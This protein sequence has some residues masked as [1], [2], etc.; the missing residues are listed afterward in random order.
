MT[1]SLPPVPGLPP[2]P[3]QSA[4]AAAAGKPAK[5]QPSQQ[6]IEAILARTAQEHR[7]S[8][9]G[10]QQ[11]PFEIVSSWL[12]RGMIARLL[13]VMSGLIL[14]NNGFDGLK[15]RAVS[16]DSLIAVS[17][18]NQGGQSVGLGFA[19]L[20]FAVIPFSSRKRD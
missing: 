11:S 8:F 17:I 10:Q 15:T 1:D 6:E 18:N 4:S 12:A 5:P 16:S 9:P 2:K 13:F 14:I 3:S 20:A 19:M 7:A